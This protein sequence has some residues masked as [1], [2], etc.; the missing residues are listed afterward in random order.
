MAFF[1]QRFLEEVVFMICFLEQRV[2]H[3]LAIIGGHRV[4]KESPGNHVHT[5]GP[6]TRVIQVLHKERL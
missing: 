4:V 5:L 6:V 3:T 2:I 1:V